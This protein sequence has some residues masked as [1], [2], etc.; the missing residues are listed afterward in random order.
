MS[1]R[2]RELAQRVTGGLVITLYWDADDNSTHVEV[3]QPAT[4]TAIAFR[5]ARDQALDA[6]H[7]P[8]AHLSY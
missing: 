1:S 4:D 5:V 3:H 7:H 8:F 6:F 2:L